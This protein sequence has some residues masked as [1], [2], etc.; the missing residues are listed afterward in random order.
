[1][2]KCIVVKVNIKRMTQMI[3]TRKRKNRTQMTDPF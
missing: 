2:N 3:S 1:M